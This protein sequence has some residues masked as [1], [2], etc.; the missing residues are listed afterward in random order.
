MNVEGMGEIKV[1]IKG[2]SPYSIEDIGYV[3]E[4]TTDGYRIV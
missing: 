4:V 3:K 1:N 2:I